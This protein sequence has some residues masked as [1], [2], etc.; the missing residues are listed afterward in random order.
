M[1]KKL[2]SLTVKGLN[3][4]TSVKFVL[5]FLTGC[6]VVLIMLANAVGIL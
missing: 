6:C 1:T 5:G 2:L 3:E 4:L